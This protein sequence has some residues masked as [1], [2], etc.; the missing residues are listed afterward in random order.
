MSAA[1]AA[2]TTTRSVL[3]AAHE[4]YAM[5]DR[6]DFGDAD[7]GLIAAIPDGAVREDDGRVSL[8][9]GWFDFLGQDGDPAPDTVDASLWRQSQLIR[10]AGLY[11]VVDGLYQVRN[12][13]I[14][15]VT[16]VEGPDGVVV[17]DCGSSVAAA[18]QAL[19]LLREH[20]TDKPV[21][22]VIYTHTHIDHYGGV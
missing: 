16:F 11:R 7:R 10:K 12:N 8:D 19:A 3:E 4:R 20:V 2:S 15:T 17:V 1:K 21:V 18:R 9:L 6:Q 13:D 22:A 14:A 5:D